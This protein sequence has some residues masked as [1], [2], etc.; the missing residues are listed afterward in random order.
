M[1]I[2]L[3]AAVARLAGA[4]CINF[5]SSYLRPALYHERKPMKT[6]KRGCLVLLLCLVFLFGAGNAYAADYGSAV[7]CADVLYELGLFRGTDTG[8][9]LETGCDR[10]M[11]AV[12]LVRF[13]GAEQ[14]ALAQNYPHP[15]TDVAESY[16]NPYVGYLYH[17]S[18]TK[19]Q[20]A[21][22]YGRGAMTGNQFATLMLRA[23]DYQD[24]LDFNWQQALGTM[25]QLQIIDSATVSVIANTDFLRADAV[26]LCYA[27][28]FAVPRTAEQP[29]VYTFLWDGLISTVQLSK[30]HDAALMLAADM[31]DYIE[32]GAVAQDLQTCRALMELAIRNG[33]CY[34]AA[35]VPGATADALVKLFEDVFYPVHGNI[36]WGDMEGWDGG[37][38][39]VNANL[40]MAQLME[41][42]YANPTRY[43]KNF[44]LYEGQSFTPLL[45]TSFY[46]EN[47]RR[48][49]SDYS[50]GQ[51]A[52]K[53]AEILA[54]ELQDGMA[55][56]EM[57]RAI[58]D[59]LVL[60]TVY[61]EE[62]E[63]DDPL[64]HLAEQVL[65]QGRGVCDGYAQAFK[66]LTN[67]AGLECVV[68]Y[69]EA[70]GVG[71]AWNQ[72]KIDGSWY[73]VDVTW[74]DPDYKD[75]IVYEYFCKRDKVFEKHLVE[76]LSPHYQCP[77]DL[78]FEEHQRAA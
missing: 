20:S 31:P 51:V 35:H 17:H 37:M 68:V 16:A 75:V 15:F 72:V 53:V 74:D 38:T 2:S 26:Q 52:A 14:E 56:A 55:E 10:L 59:Y 64:P 23:L 27:T 78:E 62:Y 1:K 40:S 22:S 45:A 73:N 50:M 34:L 25:A 60:N 65:F 69:G 76:E 66:I 13:L 6:T 7:W 36:L 42:Y 19:G 63:E 12:F 47:R 24:G 11:G 30:T 61:E 70:E 21:D 39:L 28:L 32:E 41:Y 77:Q 5:V 58:H 71:H 44:Q 49:Y 67:A 43:E 9:S 48:T 3:P 33:Q 8:Y 46:S 4:A 57:V 29:L 54:Q 18:L